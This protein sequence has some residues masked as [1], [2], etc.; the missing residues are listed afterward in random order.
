MIGAHTE[1]VHNKLRKPDPVQII[2]NTEVNLG[3]QIWAKLG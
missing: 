2:L 3:S 1:A